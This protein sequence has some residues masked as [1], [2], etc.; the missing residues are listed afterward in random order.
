M[1]HKNTVLKSINAQGETRCVDIFQRPDETFGF[2]TYRRD[3]EDS[4]GWF[5][6]GAFG[7]QVFA[8]E[9][10]ALVEARAKVPWLNDVM[11]NG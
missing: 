8:T 9:G 10:D 7:G 4:R 11:A 5:P 2:E 1:A 6:D 3:P